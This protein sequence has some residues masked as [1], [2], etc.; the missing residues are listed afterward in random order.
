MD[1]TSG[2]TATGKLRA[3]PAAWLQARLKFDRDAKLLR[4]RPSSA[5]LIDRLEQAHLTDAAICLAANALPPRE[6]VWWA[7][8]CVRHT[9]T[10]GSSSADVAARE[11]AESWVRDP[12]ERVRALAYR[13]ARRARFQSAEA[14]A[15]MGAFWSGQADIM[16]TPDNAARGQIGQSV[17]N[18]VRMSAVRGSMQERPARLRAFLQSARDIAR[19][20]A[21][22][23][24]A[25]SHSAGP[26][27]AG[28][29][30]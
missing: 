4:D 5:L 16:N 3:M 25:A 14:M 23:L 19:G 15:C 26:G 13:S 21:G 29:E 10:A 17:E 22:R 18:A 30:I 1:D 11:A 24:E 28:T 6:A 12:S 20:G 27:A 8:M 9:T 2:I 7:C